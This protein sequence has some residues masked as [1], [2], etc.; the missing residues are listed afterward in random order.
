MSRSG[1]GNGNGNRI[2]TEPRWALV[3]HTR[4]DR[5]VAKGP[6]FTHAQA[7]SFW[8]RYLAGWIKAAYILPLH[9]VSL[10]EGYAGQ[11]RWPTKSNP[12]LKVWISILDGYNNPLG[13][14]IK[15][16]PRG[17]GMGMGSGMGSGS[18]SGSGTG[19]AYGPFRTEGQAYSFSYGYGH[20][21]S[22]HILLLDR[23]L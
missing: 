8:M 13:P 5:W 7:Y 20:G 22:H 6:Y 15:P 18:G 17:M 10:D 19:S 23:A 16:S 2:M 12:G 4:E 9:S 21:H 11:G 1:N 14:A 3:I